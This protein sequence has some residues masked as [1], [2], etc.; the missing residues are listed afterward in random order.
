MALGAT[1]YKLQLSLSDIDR[2]HY[3]DHALTLAQHPSETM[4]RLLVRIIAFVF[5]ADEKLTMTRGLSSSDEPDLWRHSDDGEIQHWI[6]AGLPDAAR[7]K[8]ASHRARRVT[9]YCY[10]DRKTDVWWQQNSAA[11]LAIDNLDVVLIDTNDIA[12]LQPLLARHMKWQCTLQDN[13]AWITNATDNAGGM[14]TVTPRVLKSGAPTLQG[15]SRW[16]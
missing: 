13:A 8:K 1:L 16:A 14:A 5:E 6:E 15:S 10:G 4:E 12:Q 2:N 7:V 11:L 9:V 3:Q